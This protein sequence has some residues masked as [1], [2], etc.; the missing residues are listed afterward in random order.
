MR[1]SFPIIMSC[2]CSALYSILLSFLKMFLLFI[3]NHYML[4]SYTGVPINV[5]E[6]I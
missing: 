4:F 2:D 1:T 6:L 5:K 3:F